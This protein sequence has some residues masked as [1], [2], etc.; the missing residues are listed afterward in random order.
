M[1]FGPGP[2]WYCGRR[3]LLQVQMSPLVGHA[4]DCYAVPGSSRL[5]SLGP[6]ST[7]ALMTAVAIG[8]LA[9]GNPARYAALA[10]MLA[11]LVG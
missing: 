3:S 6:E 11:L 10:A 1:G 7:T 9:A 5:V 2:S 8:P 4:F